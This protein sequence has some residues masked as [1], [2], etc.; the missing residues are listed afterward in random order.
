MDDRQNRLRQKAVA[1]HYNRKEHA[2][3]VVAKGGGVI[4]ERILEE[5]ENADVAVYQDAQ[6]VEELTRMDLGEHIPPEL[7][8]VVAQVLIFINDLDRSAGLQGKLG[9]LG[10][11]RLQPIGP[12]NA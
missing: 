11:E 9:D 12:E 2:P 8:E 6:L 7:Y 4:A 1:L 10:L 5:A 3:R